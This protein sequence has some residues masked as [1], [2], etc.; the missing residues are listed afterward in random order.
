MR[1]LLC[2]ITRRHDWTHRPWHHPICRRCGVT[3][4]A[5]GTLVLA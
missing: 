5:R 3:L 2:V 4:N 1:A